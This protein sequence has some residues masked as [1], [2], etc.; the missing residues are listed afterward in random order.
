[1][2]A[3]IP[4]I[5]CHVHLRDFDS[6]PN[7]NIVRGYLGIERMNIVCTINP[8]SVNANPPAL[9][10]K[11]HF[12]EQFYLFA[13]LDHA[14]HFSGGRLQTPSLAEQAERLVAMG[15]DGIKMLENKPTSRKFLDV[16]VD[17]DYFEEYFARVEALGVPLLWHVADPE[18]FWDPEWTPAWAKER[19]WG[20][21]ASFPAKEQL[22]AEVEN[23]LRRHPKLR[24]IFAHF[25]FLS[26]DLP[27]A[28][29]L[30]DQYPHVHLDLAP[31]IELLYNLSRD[32]PATRD[33]FTRYA[34]RIL[35]GTDISSNQQPEEAAIRAG[36]VTR[37]VQTADEYRV[38]DGADF[39]LGP[40]EDGLMRGL[41]LPE[42]VLAKVCHANFERLVG[43]R[44]KA[45]ERELAAQECDR[46]AR[47]VSFLTGVAEEDTCAARAAGCLRNPPDEE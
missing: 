16:P 40:P 45:L 39:L 17:S 43:A 35:F 12:P 38:P 20:Y 42:E 19:G 25:F 14:A 23:V 13:G 27:R 6:V 9:V 15:A 30:L 2:A 32:V 37:W 34:D 44:P 46:Q 36:I 1:M 7:L 11:A 22:Y 33:F 21:D 10:A 24:V 18:E 8:Q 47:E 5:D 28:A 29:R 4:V 3:K 41:A 26:A 31:G